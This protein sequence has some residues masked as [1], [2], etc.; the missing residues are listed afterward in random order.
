MRKMMMTAAAA[1]CCMITMAVLTSCTESNDNPSGKTDDSSVLVG[2]WYA[3]VSGMT[4]TM[5]TYGECLQVMEFKADGTGV[6]DVYYIFDGQP[7]AQEHQTFTYTVKADGSLTMN[8]D[9]K[10]TVP[11]TQ[12]R[13]NGGKLTL[14]DGDGVGLTFTKTDGN[15]AAQF[16]EWSTRE[17][18]LVPEPARYTVLVYGIGMG[19][20]DFAIEQG[21]WERVKPLLKDHNN[22]RVVC[23]YKYGNETTGKYGKSGDIAWF[24][25][26]DETDLNNL[27]DAQGL[28]TALG[29]DPKSVKLC[30]PITLQTFF[31]F[32][33]LLCPAEEYILTTWGNGDGFDPLDDVPGKYDESPA[34]TR[35]LLGDEWNENE[36]L[37]MY[38]LAEAIKKTRPGNGGCL[39]TIFFHTGL[40]GNMEFLTELRDLADYII[41]T[42][43]ILR[44][45][46]N[47][48]VE[49]IRSLQEAEN[50][51]DAMELMLSRVRPS[52]DHEFEEEAVEGYYPP[53]GC[54]KMIRTEALNNIINA[55]KR[56]ADRVIA[57]YPTQ[58]EAIDLATKSVYRFF[59]YGDDPGYSFAYPFFDLADYARQL[60][61]A[62]GDAEMAII[63]DDMDKAFSDA[64]VHYVDINFGGQKLDH[65]TLSVILNDEVDYTWVWDS[66]RTNA[67]GYEQ[68]TF[69]KL[70]GWGN[71]L[72]MN[73]Q[74][75]WGNPTCGS[76]INTS[77]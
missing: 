25:L 41:A 69:H 5:W 76:K 53:N 72:R 55:A 21:F 68:C 57:L 9:S 22:V 16:D 77:E 42:P 66:G 48:L 52:F 50:T 36:Q 2:R 59:T 4:Y 1:L 11:A 47:I 13:I 10:K 49:F 14:A 65:Y 44:S 24:E 61:E 31:E 74:I 30:D 51:E 38:E 35:G 73:Q 27:F 17:L 19:V 18:E 60:A 28:Q 12:W 67:E 43:H 37:D 45:N 54:L 3:D 63:S 20:Q 26:N 23:L 32:S 33:S 75:L 39:N 70:T 15:M 8:I 71:W 40:M 64:F 46:G 58:R 29:D 7:I 56:L 34:V 6:T 62:T